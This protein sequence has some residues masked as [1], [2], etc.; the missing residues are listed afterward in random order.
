[1]V[2]RAFGLSTVRV[3]RS[4]LWLPGVPASMSGVSHRNCDE[5]HQ[6]LQ[7]G[8]QALALTGRHS[9]A[10]VAVPHLRRLFPAR[11]AAVAVVARA[12]LSVAVPAVVAVVAAV[13]LAL[14]C[15]H[16]LGAAITPS[17][18]ASVSGESMIAPFP[19]RPNWIYQC[20]VHHF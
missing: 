10:A 5:T 17:R 4:L 1:M 13:R 14:A 3:A 8:H 6:T 7:Q 20:H 16:R 9:L 15:R 19:T 12:R 2:E 11:H 18:A